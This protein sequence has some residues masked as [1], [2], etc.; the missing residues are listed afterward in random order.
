MAAPLDRPSDSSSERQTPETS[1]RRLR[2]Q[3]QIDFELEFLGRI[4][5]REPFFVERCGFTPTTWRPR[6]STVVPFRSIAGWSGC[7]PKTRSSGTIWPA[8]SPCWA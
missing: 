7:A 2:E 4:L 8:A 3:S 6:V 1:T 5:E